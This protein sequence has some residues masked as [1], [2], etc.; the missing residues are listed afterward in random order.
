MLQM[1][2]NVRAIGKK[3]L[4]ILMSIKSLQQLFG[5]DSFQTYSNDS[6]FLS[7]LSSEHDNDEI[8]N[9]SEITDHSLEYIAGY[10]AKKIKSSNPPLGDYTYKIK[11]HNYHLPSWVQQLSYGGLIKPTPEWHKKVKNGINTLNISTVIL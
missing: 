11:N 4:Q 2:L 9:I 8:N 7:T 1:I 10:L 6:S 3:T 5:D